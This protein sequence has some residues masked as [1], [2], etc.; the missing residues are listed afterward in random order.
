[1]AGRTSNP[2]RVR[3]EQKFVRGEGCWNWTAGKDK[4]GYGRFAV[5]GRGSY[6]RAHR[7]SFELY[8]GAVP[9][10]M[11]VLHRCDNPSCVRPDHL[12]LGV[13]QDNADDM[14]AKGRQAKGDRSGR[15]THPER[16]ARGD[17]QGLRLHPE[18]RAFGIR[19]ARYTHPETTARG[20]RNGF[21]KLDAA[22]VQ[23]IRARHAAGDSLS[24]LSRIFSV[25][26]QCIRAVV[27]RKTWAHVA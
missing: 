16:T 25:T 1:M 9:E 10:G 24:A 15:H 11:L 21:A 2:P 13:Y 14:V 8:V 7:F 27:I 26:V 23:M 3:F 12:F 19:N 20:E 22:R 17:R 18:R 5:P 4:D 6:L